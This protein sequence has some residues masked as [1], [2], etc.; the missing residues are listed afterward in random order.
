MKIDII[1]SIML[2]KIDIIFTSYLFP[3]LYIYKLL[4]DE[5]LYREGDPKE[6]VFFLLSG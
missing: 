2:F 3:Q 6:E 5:M 4:K 1:S